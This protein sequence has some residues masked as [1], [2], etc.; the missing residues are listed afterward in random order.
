MFK[1]AGMQPEGPA[2]KLEAQETRFPDLGRYVW[3]LAAP[4]VVIIAASAAWNIYI[5]RCDILEMA[6]IE[7]R[8]ALGKDVIYRRWN[9]MHGGVYVPV[10]EETPPSPY[11]SH[12]PERDIATPSGKRLTLMNPAYMTRQAH[13]LMR[14][15]SG[16]QGHITSLKPI[17]P[18]NVADEWETQALEAFEHGQ[19]EVSAVVMA[20]GQE[21]MRL[22]RPLIT[23]NKCLSCHAKQG[24][25]EDDVR[26]AIGVTVP[27]E[28]L[29]ALE[30]GK[31]R[32]LVLA[33][34]LIG[35]M[36]LAGLWAGTKRLRRTEAHRQRA[37]EALAQL[38]AELQQRASQLEAARALHEWL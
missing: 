29:R 1:Q 16:V 31:T 24:Y 6:R 37:E 20:G 8:T 22:I 23:E 17:R 27:M 10:T 5:T 25:R 15:T 2:S 38:N 12:M 4:W 34:A 30:D 28:P 3:V 11:L 32:T 21:Q 9:A 26:G 14:Q 13:E 36:G 7:A 19:S 35:L 33:H 18:D